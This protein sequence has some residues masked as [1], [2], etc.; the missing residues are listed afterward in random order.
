MSKHRPTSQYWHSPQSD[1]RNSA[2]QVVAIG[3]H[4]HSLGTYR[5]RKLG[6]RRLRKRKPHPGIAQSKSPQHSAQ[7]RPTAI[8]ARI[9]FFAG[10]ANAFAA[11]LALTAI[12]ARIGRPWV[13]GSFG[14][15]GSI[16]VVALRSVAL[17]SR[18][19]CGLFG[20]SPAPSAGTSV[21]SLR[22]VRQVARQEEPRFP[23]LGLELAIRAHRQAGSHHPPSRARSHPDRVP[24]PRPRR[25]EDSATGHGANVPPQVAWKMHR[26]AFRPSVPLR[27]NEESGWIDECPRAAHARRYKQPACR[28]HARTARTR[29]SFAISVQLRIMVRCDLAGHN[30]NSSGIF[31]SS[32]GNP[33]LHPSGRQETAWLDESQSR[34]PA[35]SRRQWTHSEEAQTVP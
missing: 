20:R 5:R 6:S 8:K 27:F 19:R 11:D 32:G 25:E 13:L 33:E 31:G 16:A 30:R 24:W 3:Q 21:G 23:L 15:L 9:Q 14:R 4:R 18:T 17:R 28:T 22:R 7:L 34:P 29:R 10:R 12:R 1:R 35:S 2:S 26:T